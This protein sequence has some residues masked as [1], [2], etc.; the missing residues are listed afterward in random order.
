M[1]LPDALM[2]QK[3]CRCIF[4]EGCN[5]YLALRLLMFLANRG[6]VL[7]TLLPLMPIIMTLS[8]ESATA[9]KLDRV[10]PLEGELQCLPKSIRSVLAC[11]VWLSSTG[12]RGGP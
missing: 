7:M 4:L 1:L 10:S 9:R 11:R 6:N 2:C 8:S 5:S 12:R 3:D